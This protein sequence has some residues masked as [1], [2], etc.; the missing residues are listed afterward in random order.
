MLTTFQ[1]ATQD[2]FRMHGA[3]AWRHLF[4]F[5]K[6]LLLTKKKE[7]GNLLVKDSIMVNIHGNQL[8]FTTMVASKKCFVVVTVSHQLCDKYLLQLWNFSLWEL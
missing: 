8:H 1:F 4:L 3:K 2:V 7:D 5:E 6:G